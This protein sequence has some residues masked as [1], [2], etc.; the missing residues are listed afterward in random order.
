MFIF[1]V[2]FSSTSSPWNFYIVLCATGGAVLG[3][4]DKFPE[5]KIIFKSLVQHPDIY[6]KQQIFIN[7]LKNISFIK[8][9][10]N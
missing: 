7:G 8:I 2:T 1:Y 10:T 3:V 9:I 6:I 5:P 4:I